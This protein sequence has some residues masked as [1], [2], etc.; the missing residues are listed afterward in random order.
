M[1]NEENGMIEKHILRDFFNRNFLAAIA[2]CGIA[3]TLYS[4]SSIASEQNDTTASPPTI[5]ID[6]KNSDRNVNYEKVNKFINTLSKIPEL[7]PAKTPAPVNTAH[8]SQPASDVNIHVINTAE[9]VN[10]IKLISLLFAAAGLMIASVLMLIIFSR[11][12]KS[13]HHSE[14]YSG[15]MNFENG[16]TGRGMAFNFNDLRLTK[17]P[18][19]TSYMDMIWTLGRLSKNNSVNT[20]FY[21]AYFIPSYK[22]YAR[23]LRRKMSE[24]IKETNINCGE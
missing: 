23:I 22:N 13:T 18:M 15:A 17:G 20:Y 19:H 24:K 9:T 7:I 4:A 1:D 14:I 16:M 6:V 11:Y 10:M 12:S 5:T 8:K 21:M 2:A 3:I